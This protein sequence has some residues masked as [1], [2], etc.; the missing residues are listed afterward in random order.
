MVTS[1]DK[2]FP[3]SEMMW[4]GDEASGGREEGSE[5]RRSRWGWSRRS[6]AKTE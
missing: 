3:F 1:P 4:K 2:A 6:G 5:G